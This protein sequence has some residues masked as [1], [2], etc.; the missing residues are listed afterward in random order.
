MQKA[1][2]IVIFT[3]LSIA[4]SGQLVL[5]LK[6]SARADSIFFSNITQDHEFQFVHYSSDITI[7]LN[8]SLNDLYNLTFYTG[9][10]KKMNQLWLNGDRVTIK[11]TFT[12]KI[13]EVDTVIGT[14][15]YYKSLDF[16]KRFEKQ[17]IQSADSTV[18]NNFL[19]EELKQNLDNIFSIEIAR[20]FFSRNV[21]RK[22]ELKKLLSLLSGQDA[23]IKKHLLN[24][25][26]KIENILTRGKLEL[27]KF[28]FY[29]PEGKLA[30]LTLATGKRYMI[31]MWF[32][33][34]APCIEQHH[35]ISNSLA[36]LKNNNIEV[37]GISVD[38]NH[39]QWKNFLEKKKYGWLNVREI[40][41]HEQRL[42]TDMLIES[43][44]T[45]FLINDAG[46][47]LYRSNS[48]REMTAFLKL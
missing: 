6:G 31:D 32:V 8:G 29:S 46:T 27:G 16:R 1:I 36:T 40:D 7:K 3:L 5:Q 20:N 15:L 22:D 10:D 47:I 44:P 23:N 42:R 19:L 9:Q 38:Q 33:G 37:I 17:M 11:G 45:Y 26:K 30:S 41:K 4:S 39:D 13:L 21:S 25:Y 2:F 14:S 24:P 34:C 43:Y 18:I 48:F 12:G 28:K 35:E